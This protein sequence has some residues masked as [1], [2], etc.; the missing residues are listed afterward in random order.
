MLE[1][2]GEIKR[3]YAGRIV[4]LA[5]LLVLLL[6]AAVHFAGGPK[7]AGGPEARKNYLT[8]LG[9]ELAD[10]QEEHQTVV[11]PSC[12]EGAM[13]EYNALLQKG[14]FDLSP[15]E[16]KT[17][18]QYQYALTQTRFNIHFFFSFLATKVRKTALSSKYPCTIQKISLHLQSRK[19][20]FPTYMQNSQPEQNNFLYTQRP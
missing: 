13:R 4:A 11:I 15:Y 3:K 19:N 9:W 20:I 14:G 8:S 6:A 10:G 12:E 18:D 16:G 5:L 2:K 1:K 7:N 17:V